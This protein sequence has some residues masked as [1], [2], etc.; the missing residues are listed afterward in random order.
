MKSKNTLVIISLLFI[1][2]IYFH[3]LAC[4]SKTQDYKRTPN[5]TT[6]TF[7]EFIVPNEWQQFGVRPNEVVTAPIWRLTKDSLKIDTLSMT[8]NYYRDTMYIVE[9]S[10]PKYDSIKK[11]FDTIRIAPVLPNKFI[12]KDLNINPNKP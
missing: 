10:I 5:D 9:I 1:G 7:V 3:V 11:K 4:Q 2:F 12:S 8:K 6:Q